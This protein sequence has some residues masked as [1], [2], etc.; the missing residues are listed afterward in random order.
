M[1]FF[2]NW[3]SAHSVALLLLILLSVFSVL[4]IEK[5]TSAFFLDKTH[6]IRAGHVAHED[7]FSRSAYSTFVLFRVKSGESI[8]DNRLVN[9]LELLHSAV[10]EISLL[11]W[12]DHQQLSERYDLELDQVGKVFAGHDGALDTYNALVKQH[13]RERLDRDL[14]Q[15][16]FPVRSIKSLLNTDN[17]YEYEDEIVIESS[18]MA[19]AN[20]L[21]ETKAHIAKNPLLQG[22]MFSVDEQGVLAQIEY[23]IDA[24]DTKLNIALFEKIEAITAALAEQ[25]SIIESAHYAGGPVLNNALSNVMEK[26]NATYFPFVIL[27]VLVL[28]VMFY[29]SLLCALYG[30]SIA[31]LSIL[32]TMALMP[33]FGVSLNIV[34]TVLPVFIITIAVTDAIHVMSDVSSSNA[35]SSSDSKNV[36]VRQSIQ[37]LFRPMLLTSLTTGLGFLSLSFTEITNIRGFGIMVA[38]SVVIAFVLSVT[39]LPALLSLRPIS[40]RS[41]SK[42]GPGMERFISAVTKRQWPAAACLTIAFGLTLTGLPELKVDQASIASFD[43]GSR[44]RQDN[45]QFVDSGSGS[46]VLNVWLHGDKENAILAP[47][48]LELIKETQ[49]IIRKHETYVDSFSMVDFLDRLH[50]VLE[51]DQ[52]APLDL[53]DRERVRQYLFLLESGADRDLESVATVG[54]YKQTRIAISLAQDNSAAISDMLLDIRAVMDGG[55]PG[56]IEVTYAGYAAIVDVASQEILVAQFN[57]L[58]SSLLASFIIFFVVLR[59]VVVALVGMLPLA[60]TL[61]TMFGVMGHFGFPLDIGSSLVAGIAFG[62]GIDYSIH[63]IEAIRRAASSSSLSSSAARSELLGRALREVAKPIGISAIV[64]SSGFSL[65]LLSGFKPLA[66]LGLLIMVAMLVSAVFS[67]VIMPFILNALPQSSFG[68][69]VGIKTGRSLSVSNS[70]G[71]NHDDHNDLSSERLAMLDLQHSE[72]A[73]NAGPPEDLAP[74]S[75]TEEKQP[76]CI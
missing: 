63:V 60:A 19:R 38:I 31:V 27:F 39:V 40:A 64:L 18:Y 37:K 52:S 16:L 15:F 72:G 13:S 58:L 66:S 59:S 41:S 12:V 61:A 29:R 57:S 73:L 48:V 25:N 69:V 3:K 50:V 54:D 10:D 53:S 76:G 43:E 5:N 35:G 4:N 23:A 17:I 67:L 33:V 62:I 70:I 71:N 9:T 32:F 75:A 34:T 1:H 26:D 68:S 47:K 8:Y 36:A 11:E 24:E 28:L 51:G 20:W 46:V 42:S 6:P 22:G 65:L 7:V 14:G 74:N 56:G 55:L 30:L 2:T 21:D 49:A 44:L 45:A